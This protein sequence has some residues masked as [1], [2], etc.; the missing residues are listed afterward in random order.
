MS[1]IRAWLT[2]WRLSLRRAV[3]SVGMVM[4]LLPLAL[5]GL[6][7]LRRQ[8]L[9]SDPGEFER[10]FQR[11]ATFLLMVFV[12]I[13]TPICAL[14]LG[15]SG[16]G[17]EREDRTLLY[18]LV[19]PIP[20][21]LILLAKF[22]AAAPLTLSLTLGSFWIYCRL[23]GEVGAQAFPRF[24]P[25]IGLATLAYLGVFCFFSVTFRH[26]TIAA[27]LYALFI[28]VFIGNL[29]GIV[30]RIAIDYYARD[31]IFEAGEELGL[32]APNAKIFE[33]VPADEAALVLSLIALGGLLLATL[34]FRAR[35][36]RDL[37]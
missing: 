24:Y 23:A 5:C 14:A 25:A 3:F 21:S 19:R 22:L 11:F 33:R 10:D 20:R 16:V 31:M 28:E 6:F 34:V 37:T 4:A 36:Y 8:G 32:D 30:K 17:G 7:M 1:L 27:V 29:P 15:T 26:S 35:E 12:P 18:L 2:L 9:G 13:V